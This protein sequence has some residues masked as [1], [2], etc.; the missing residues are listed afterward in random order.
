[1]TPIIEK[2]IGKE[3]LEQAVSLNE[4]NED[5]FKEFIRYLD[6]FLTELEQ[7]DEIE[8]E[9]TAASLLIVP[10]EHTNYYSKR[11]N[12]GFSITWSIKYAESK[13]SFDN[14]NLL[15]SCF[16][17]SEEQDKQ[18]ADADLMN[19]FKITKRDQ[20]FIDYFLKRISTGDRFGDRSIEKDVEK[21]VLNYNGKISKGK[22]KLYAY[23]Y[24][25]WLING[26]HH[27]FCD[28]YAYIYEE[29]INNG[30]NEEYAMEYAYQ[31]ANELVDVKRRYGI[32]NDEESLDFAKAKAKAHIN[33]WEYATENKLKSYGKFMEYYKNAYLNTLYSDD[34]NEWER[35][36]QCE[37][38]ALD[39]AL[40]KYERI[41]KK[42]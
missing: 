3:A 23:Q 31:Y 14:S 26:Y 33:A 41:I 21:F 35:I 42:E 5:S 40:A 32:S 13:I 15:M 9:D 37:K 4:Y 18:Q 36:E 30:K 19:Y 11:R 38:I 27:L 1:M 6:L 28:D 16:E 10:I 8:N 20:L 7:D 29:S 24:A 25:D 12:E 2:Y 17:A 22:S 34:P 39:K